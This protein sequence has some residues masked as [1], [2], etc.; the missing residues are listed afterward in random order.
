M[1]LIFQ[2][3]NLVHFANCQ[4]ID[5]QKVGEKPILILAN[6]DRFFEIMEVVY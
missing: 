4:N 5:K 3:E 1:K 6:E 2:R